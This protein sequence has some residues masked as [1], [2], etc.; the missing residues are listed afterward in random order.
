MWPRS[1]RLQT[2]SFELRVL[3]APSLRKRWLRGECRGPKP[4]WGTWGLRKYPHWSL[5]LGC[6]GLFLGHHLPPLWPWATCL[7]TLFLIFPVYKIGRVIA[8][9]SY[10]CWEDWV[11]VYKAV[12]AMSGTS[13]AVRA[14]YCHRR[15]HLFQA[16]DLDRGLGQIEQSLQEKNKSALGVL[17]WAQML[18]G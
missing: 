7:A 12:G 14:R 15:H 8:P 3:G 16:A 6:L 1:R 2:R 10:S 4:P 9:A 17:P 11:I 18:V 13:Y 5:E